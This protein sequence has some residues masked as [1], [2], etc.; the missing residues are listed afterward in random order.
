[1]RKSPYDQ[2]IREELAKLGHVGQYDPRHIEAYMRLQYSTLDY[3]SRNDF[4]KEI[5]I[6]IGCIN[7]GGIEAAE[8]CAQSYGM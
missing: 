3:L 1:M 5:K 6:C 8:Q 7:E 2:T 4:Q